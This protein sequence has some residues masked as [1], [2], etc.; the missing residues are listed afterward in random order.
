MK[1]K[2]LFIFLICK[3]SF[4]FFSCE[5]ELPTDIQVT[6]QLCF[7]CILNPDSLI[8][9]SVSLSQSI[10]TNKNIEKVNN[11]FIELR[12]N[13]EIIGIMQN[14]GNGIYKLE[15]KPLSGSRYDIRIKAEGYPVLSAST[16][17][18]SKPEVSYQLSNPVV[19]QTGY[20]SYTS[21]T[22]TK[23]IVDKNGIN[24]YWHYR[25]MLGKTN[26]WG[27]A[28]GS[29]NVDSPIIDDFNRV[30]DAMDKLGF[31]YEYY[32]RINDIGMDGETLTFD[33]I[34]YQN[35]INFFMDTDIHYD[36][37]M[38]STIKQRMNDGDNLLFNEPVQI[39]SNIENGLGIFGSTAITSFKL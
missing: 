14:S 10:S 29:Y 15:I 8:H 4:F 27:F 35:E 39:Y 28:G 13:G 37:Y 2:I 20:N 24:R 7:N 11:A 26:T 6:P 33:D 31:H 23:N 5:K 12:K 17:I 38:K 21:Y 3:F 1:Q 34:A 9:G 18:P 19:H 30:T 16:I 22:I 25:L 36:K 32:L